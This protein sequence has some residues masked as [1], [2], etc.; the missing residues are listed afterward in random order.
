MTFYNGDKF[1]IQ[2][3]DAPDSGTYIDI[4]CLRSTSLSINNEQIDVTAKCNTPWRVL[5]EGGI[6]TM[7]LS[8]GGVFS[9]EASLGLMNAAA[10]AGSILRYRIISEYT[11]IYEGLFQ[12]STMERSGEYNDAEQYSL[13][14]ESSGEIAY[15]AP[16]QAP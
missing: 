3:E 8:G 12:I 15:T 11:D 6:R 1:V 7:A 10:L 2:V 9:D 16:P 14:L 13:S 5:L 4:A